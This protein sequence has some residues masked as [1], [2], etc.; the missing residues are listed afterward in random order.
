MLRKGR[1]LTPFPKRISIRERMVSWLS[2]ITGWMT[3][4]E[5]AAIVRNA[6]QIKV[7]LEFWW[8]ATLKDVTVAKVV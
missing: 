8:S 4:S 2:W 7:V 6:I 1:I 5:S 3:I